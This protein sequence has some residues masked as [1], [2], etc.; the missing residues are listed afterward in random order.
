[1][2]SMEASIGVGN[3]KVSN[4]RRRIFPLRLLIISLLTLGIWEDYL[5]LGDNN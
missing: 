4:T 1:M 3:L 2:N 5:K